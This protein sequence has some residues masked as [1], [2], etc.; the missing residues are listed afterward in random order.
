[1][2]QAIENRAQRRAADLATYPHRGSGQNDLDLGLAHVNIEGAICHRGRRQH[3]EQFRRCCSR[4]RGDGSIF[5]NQRAEL[6]GAIVAAPLEQEVRIDPVLSRKLC[7]RDARHAR[8]CTEPA[9]EINRM[10]RAALAA[11]PGYTLCCQSSPHHLVGGHHSGSTGLHREDG[12]G[13]TL[14]LM[15]KRPQYLPY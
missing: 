6:P 4:R 7:H 12:L 1:M 10:I 2:C 14:T 5:W 9:F 11:C 8:Q 15:P 13:A 3:R